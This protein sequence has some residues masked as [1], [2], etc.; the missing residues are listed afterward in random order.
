[1]NA[2]PCGSGSTAL[3]IAGIWVQITAA[4]WPGSEYWSWAVGLDYLA[5]TALP[6]GP[7]VGI[8]VTKFVELRRKHK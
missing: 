1:M 2:D 5:S 3:I 7:Q 4:D 8:T 6:R